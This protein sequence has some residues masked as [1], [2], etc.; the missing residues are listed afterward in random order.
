MVRS[1]IAL[2]LRFR[3]SDL[4]TG[5]P[6]INLTLS[7]KTTEASRL[8]SFTCFL[9]VLGIYNVVVSRRENVAH[10]TLAYLML[11]E[12]GTLNACSYIFNPCPDTVP[13]EE[14]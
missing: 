3:V 2:S 7:D 12:T 6:T 4:T 11:Q 14:D 8:A 13:G 9:L 5:L 1:L 10:L